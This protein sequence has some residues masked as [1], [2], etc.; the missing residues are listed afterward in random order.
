MLGSRSN[1]KSLDCSFVAPLFDELGISSVLVI[2]NATSVV[3]FLGGIGVLSLHL[4]AY[5]DE[6]AI[7]DVL[8]PM[9]DAIDDD[10][11]AVEAVEHGIHA[12]EDAAVVMMGRVFEDDAS[13]HAWECLHLAYGI[14]DHLYGRQGGL[15]V[16]A[17]E[18]EIDGDGFAI[19]LRTRP[20]FDLM[21]R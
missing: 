15:G 6:A 9:Q 5:V 1:G 19:K 4:F 16:L 18:A 2:D 21:H 10:A 3:R 12:G 11:L 7:R 20:P 17:F 8:A 13:T 14:V